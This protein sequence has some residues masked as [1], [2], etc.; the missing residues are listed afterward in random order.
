MWKN[1][2]KTAWRNLLKNRLS[3]LINI[4]GLGF[5]IPFALLSIIQVQSSFESDNFHPYPNRTFRIITDLTDNMG[6]KTKYASSPQLLHEISKEYPAIDKSSFVVRDFEWELNNR[7]KNLEVNTIFV[8]PSFFDMFGFKFITG[9][10][11]IEPNS[12][13]ITQEKAEAFFGTT[14]VVGKVL[15]HQKY[16]DFIISGVLAPF[17]RNT[18]FR[19]DVMVSM[20]TRNKFIT[21]SSMTELSGFT[22]FLMK[23]NAG[24][25]NLDAALFS[26]SNR[27]N[28]QPTVESKKIKMNFRSQAV[29]SMAPDFDEL[30]DNPYVDDIYDLAL[31]FSFALGLLL[32]AAFNYIN[33]TLARSLSRAK[34]VGIRKVAGALKRQ[35]VVQFICEAVLVAIISLVFGYIVLKFLERFSYVNWFAWRVDNVVVLWIS[36]ILFT[37]AIGTVAGII[38]AKILARFQPVK[39][40]KG[41]VAPTGFGKMSLRN[42][43]VVIQFVV[44]ACFIFLMATLFSQFKYMATDNVN[45]NRKNIY[46][47]TVSDGYRLLQNDLNKN[48]DVS[49]IGLVSVPFGGATAQAEVKKNN[50]SPNVD[51][52]YYAADAD[53]VNNMNLTI[54]AG[55]NLPQAGD[56]ASAFVLV[57]EQLLTALGLGK[58]ADAVG[59]TFL[60]NNNHEVRITGVL[61]NFCYNA[62]QFAAKPLILQYNPSQFK[63]L[64]IETKNKVN[65]DA[66]KAAINSVW[67]KYYPHDQLAFSDYQHDLY[68]RY[69]PGK[70]MK[71]MGMFC[72][73][74]LIIAVLGL[75]GIVTFQ[76]EKRSKEV[77]IR[78]ILGAPVFAI[79]REL[80]GS[81]VKLT[82]IAASIALPV[83][84]ICCYIFLSLFT[85]KEGLNFTLLIAIFICIFSIALFTIIYKAITAALSNPVQNLRN[86]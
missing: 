81:F 61:T 72:I 80:S 82:I 40:L 83:G 16:G 68:N 5:A 18:V 38:P 44:T 9:S 21:D 39:V 13:V 29:T 50:Q 62:Y 60:L 84:Y 66:F 3:S 65:P 86:E 30:R 2:F 34:E 46:N 78:R 56:S 47:I 23:P 53:F 27:L 64:C 59:K 14:D 70:D 8:E 6:V 22:Y 43:L 48:S 45:F 51:A 7:I 57:N 11:P 37:V 55:S 31:N 20:A 4:I 71:F 54:V 77:G 42:T 10:R 33:L 25:K 69:F 35:L 74:L 58:A 32:L 15:A 63:V 1:Y 85:Y 28:Q 76:T 67:E 41:T 12:I 19:S 79:V 24:K 26:L 17:R 75:L 52:S 49:R 73:A 36:F